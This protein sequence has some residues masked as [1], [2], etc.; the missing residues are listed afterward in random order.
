MTEAHITEP[1]AGQLAAFRAADQDEAVMMVN[2]LK[3]REWADYGPGSVEPKRTGRDAYGEYAKVAMQ[4]IGENGGHLSFVSE[5]QQLFV[6]SED[7]DWDVVAIVYY[8]SRAAYL[9]GF[10]ST[11]YQAAIK[12]RFAGL[13][14]RVILQCGSE[15]DSKVVPT[16]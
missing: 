15:G 4:K 5:R 9:K 16:R 12:H 6:G 13:E 7:Q 11:E 2:L 1:D 10:D 3:F 14:R 8:P